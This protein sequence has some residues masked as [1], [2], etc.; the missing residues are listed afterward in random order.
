[1]TVAGDPQPKRWKLASPLPRSRPVHPT[2]LYSTL[3]GLILAIFLWAWYPFRR[4]DG[5]VTA[6]MI[7]LYPISRFLMES[8]R[9]DEPKNLLGMTISQNISL[10]LLVL[11]IALW[12]YLLRQAPRVSF[13][14]AV[15]GAG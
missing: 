2:Q 7:T 9:T 13:A 6:W 3:D 8:I 14:G 4:R 10:A 15:E 12:C 1:M 5:E 11:G